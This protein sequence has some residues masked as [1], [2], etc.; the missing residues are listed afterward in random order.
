IPAREAEMPISQSAAARASTSLAAYGAPEAPV[1]PTKTLIAGPLVRALRSVEEGR[2]VRQLLVAER[3]ELRH[4][5]VPEL[6]RV[7][8]VALEEGDT[9][10]GLPDRGQGRRAEGGRGR[11]ELGVARPT[12]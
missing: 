9:L 8:D 12:A 5:L 4:H 6:R 11:P 10:I 7:R 2:E 3:R 1:M